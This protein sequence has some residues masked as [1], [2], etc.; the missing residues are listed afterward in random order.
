MTDDLFNI[1]VY[2][3]YSVAIL[4]F[5][6]NSMCI[7]SSHWKFHI[8]GFILMEINTLERGTNKYINRH[9]GP[10]GKTDGD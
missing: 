7:I 8:I 10:Q 4:Y 6:V 2:I 3:R 1:Y 5:F 9:S